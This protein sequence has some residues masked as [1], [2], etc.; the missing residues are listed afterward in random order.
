MLSAKSVTDFVLAVN[1]YLSSIHPHLELLGK[2]FYGIYNEF[3]GSIAFEHAEDGVILVVFEYIDWENTY[4]K[5]PLNEVIDWLMCNKDELI[6]KIVEKKLKDRI[7]HCNSTSQECNPTKLRSLYFEV[8]E[9]RF[10][11]L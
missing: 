1:V 9:E 3:C 10:S 11:N 5:I 4:E 8:L 2:I 7:E 6:I